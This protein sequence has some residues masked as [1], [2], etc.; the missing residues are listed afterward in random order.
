MEMTKQK[1][2][3][4]DPANMPLVVLC[5]EDERKHES[6]VYQFHNIETMSVVSTGYWWRLASFGLNGLLLHDA[7]VIESESDM[8][9]L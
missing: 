3:M 8:S 6:M 4:T 2:P 9:I 5:Q 1:T 7:I